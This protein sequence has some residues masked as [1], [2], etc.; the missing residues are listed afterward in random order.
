MFEGM[1]RRSFLQMGMVAGAAAVAPRRMRAQTI[2]VPDMVFQARA[3]AQKTPIKTT[4]L[5]DNVYLLQG[6]GGNRARLSDALAS[7]SAPGAG[8]PA[9]E[10][11][12]RE[13]LP[14][15]CRI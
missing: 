14:G 1:N 15:T 2:P 10:S 13:S 12:R 7:Q 4:K 8:V 5:Y 6:I 11:N 3:G 9:V